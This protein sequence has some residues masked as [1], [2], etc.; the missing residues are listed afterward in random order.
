VHKNTS[1]HEVLSGG[2]DFFFSN[3]LPKLGDLYL[4][5]SKELCPDGKL[6]YKACIVLPIRYT[7]TEDEVGDSASESKVLTLG[8]LAV[9]TNCV[10]AY[11]ELYDIELGGIVADALFPVLWR[12][13]IAKDILHRNRAVAEIQPQVGSR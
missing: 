9:D 4:N 8:F 10:D 7:R 6:S 2:K 5:T 13:E 11:D 12:S 3:N 1:Y